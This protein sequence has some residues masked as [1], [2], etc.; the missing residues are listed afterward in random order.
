MS[1]RY[2]LGRARRGFV[3]IKDEA[4]DLVGMMVDVQGMFDTIDVSDGRLNAKDA[5]Q[6]HANKRGQP[7]Y[8][9]WLRQIMLRR[10]S[11][12][13]RPF[14][15]IRK[16]G[17][18]RKE[19]SYSSE[20]S[21]DRFKFGQS[22]LIGIT[23]TAFCH[24]VEAMINVIVDQSALCFA[25]RLFHRMKLLCEIETGALFLEHLDYATQMSLCA[26]E[27]LHNTRM[28]FVEVLAAH[29]R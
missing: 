4:R 16:H 28:A 20:V 14:R 24:G 5:N 12:Q 3:I 19:F 18:C 13:L 23:P 1:V 22:A 27:A 6:R 25:H 2:S 7:G 9:R 26:F 15:A 29:F 21:G 17:T 10:D 8:G 11:Y